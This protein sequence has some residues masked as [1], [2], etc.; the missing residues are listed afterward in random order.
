MQLLYCFCHVGD[1]EA[2]I[3]W[4]KG[5]QK[6]QPKKKDKR[7]KIDWDTADD[8]TSLSISDVTIEDSGSYLVKATTKDGTVSELV[9]VTV[10]EAETVQIGKNS[11][12]PRAE[13]RA[14]EEVIEDEEEVAQVSLKPQNEKAIESETVG[15]KFEIAPEPVNVDVGGEFTL[16]CKI[17]GLMFPSYALAICPICQH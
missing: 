9:T 14:T 1:S 16:K 7:L 11:K 12:E 13:K 5:D 10:N 3:T 17:S 15:P 4:F 8:L 6:I 2:E